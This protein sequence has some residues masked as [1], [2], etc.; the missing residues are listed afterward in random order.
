MSRLKKAR[1][2]LIDL[3]LFAGAILVVF[4]IWQLLTPRLNQ[5][6]KT[7]TSTSSADKVI[8]SKPKP[9]KTLQLVAIG[10]SLT[11]GVGD[12]TNK[13]GYVSLV[14]N[15]IQQATKHPVK[16]ANFGVTGDTS[17]QITKRVQKQKPLQQQLAKA[18][19]VTLT[20]GGNDLMAVLQ[21]NFFELN[22]RRITTGQQK[23]QANLTTLMMQIRKYNPDA[24]IF[25][26]GVYNP[27]YVYFPEITGMSKAV[28]EWNQTA[29]TVANDFKDT[30]YVNSD[31][32]LTRGDGHF[33]KQTKSLAK[34]DSAQLQKT[35]A[36][37]EHLNPY[38]SPDDHFHPNHKGYQWVTKAF[39]QVMKAHK[40]TW[41]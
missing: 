29:K 1:Q 41:D 13:E 11:H 6:P 22:Q 24:P 34:M 17:V 14:A 16:T 30:Y 23:Y 37:N 4:I 3:G 31:R 26:M 21:N 35:L 8:K 27:F 2:I 10:D 5:A 19:I 40:Q 9:K 39:W 32:M 33:V 38:I 7:V 20:V 12:E 28:A 18:D 15:Q 25:I 36:A